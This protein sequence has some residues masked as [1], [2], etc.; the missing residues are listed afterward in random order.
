[1]SDLVHIVNRGPDIET[2]NYWDTEHAHGGL[3]YLSGNAGVLRFLVPPGA[4]ILLTE[5]RTGH[6]ATIETS[7]HRVGLVDVVFEDGTETPFSVAIDPRQIER[8]LTPG[9]CTLTVWISRGKI[10]TLP[11][12]VKET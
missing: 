5:M 3:C 7:M 9:H 12:Q 6:S 10:L 4:E 8:A 1:M 2:T 11:C